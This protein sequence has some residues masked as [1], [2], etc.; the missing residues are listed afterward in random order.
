M[1][2]FPYF[3]SA[4]LDGARINGG[5]GEFEGWIGMIVFNVCVWITIVALDIHLLAFEFTDTKSHVHVLQTGALTSVATSAFTMLAFTF[6]HFCN[7]SRPFSSGTG[8]GEEARLLPPFATSLIVGGLRATLGFTYLI[9]LLAAIDHQTEAY[10]ILVS[11][12]AL[13]HFGTA[14][15]M[16][17]QRLAVYTNV[18]VVS[19]TS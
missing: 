3:W 18:N 8:D 4:Q 10:K 1:V 9:V 13:K 2:A 5:E 12:I 16:A 6:Y 15:A 14:M 11:Q 7:K 17:N 19:A